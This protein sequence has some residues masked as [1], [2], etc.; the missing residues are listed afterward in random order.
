MADYA[1]GKYL[2]AVDEHTALG[3]QNYHGM[4]LSVQRRLRQRV[5][6]QR[7]LHADQ[8]QWASDQGCRP[9]VNSGYVNPDDIDFDY[10]ACDSD[11]R[12]LFNLTASAETPRS[13]NAVAARARVGLAPVGHLPR[14]LGVAALGDGDRPIPPRTGIGGQRANQ[15]LDDPYGDTRSNT[16]LNRAAFASPAVGTLGNMKRNSVYG[17]GQPHFRPVAGEV[18]P[19]QRQSPHRGAHRVVQRAE[20]VPVE[21]PE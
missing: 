20:L 2:G 14:L 17:P 11:R 18:L 3:T 7:E 13:S 15:M 10:G 21:Q 19:L 9:N 5:Q 8:V 16:Y 4:L 6:R 12:H 1:D